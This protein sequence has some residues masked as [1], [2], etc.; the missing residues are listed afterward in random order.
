MPPNGGTTVT[1]KLHIYTENTVTGVLPPHLLNKEDD[2]AFCVA[3]VTLSEGTTSFHINNFTDQPYKLKKG[4]TY[5]QF[6][7]INTGTNEAFQTN[8]PRVYLAFAE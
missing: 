6:L 4:I 5:N 8:R 1:V 3:I 7:G 2:I